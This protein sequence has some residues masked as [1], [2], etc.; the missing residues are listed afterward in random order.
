MGVLN[1]NAAKIYEQDLQAL[2]NLEELNS[3]TL[4][5]RLQVVN[6]VE[7]E[8]GSKASEAESTIEK[9]RNENNK[10]VEEYKNKQLSDSEKET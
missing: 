2:L 6:L 1:G 5:V 10:L 8:D 9:I 3:N 7:S 4:N